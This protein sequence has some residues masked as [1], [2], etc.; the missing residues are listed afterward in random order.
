MSYLLDKKLKRKRYTVAIFFLFLFLI[1]FQ[2]YTSIFSGLSYVSNIVFRPFL[3]VGNS[4]RDQFGNFSYYLSSKNSLSKENENFR[5][6]KLTDE[7]KMANYDSIVSE[8]EKLKEILGRVSEHPNLVLATILVKPSQ[9]VYDT[10]VVDVGIKQ[11]VNKGSMVYALG[12]IPVGH[13]DMVY[14]DTSRIVLFSNPGE[15]T[16]VSIRDISF[17]LIGRGGGNFEMILPRDVVLEKGE[18]AVL[19]GITPRVVGIVETIISDPRDAF[20]KALLV[21]PVNISELRFVEIEK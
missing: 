11:G 14:E 8:N 17:D 16:G 15:K 18:Q 2:F 13:V 20:K 4:V 9:S 10:L 19:P 12:N 3:S 7:A 21:S 1:I 6:Q 5:L